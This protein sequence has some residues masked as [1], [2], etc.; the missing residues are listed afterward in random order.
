VAK[1]GRRQIEEELDRG[2]GS[3]ALGHPIV[4][5]YLRASFQR[6][7]LKR[8]R[9]LA[10]C[11]MP[12]HVHVVVRLYTSRSLDRVVEEWKTRASKAARSELHFKGTFWKRE[13]YQH[14]IR[15]GAELDRAL[16]YVLE[17]PARAGISRR[18]CTWSTG[19]EE[20][21]ILA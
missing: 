9:L 15:D 17:N 20:K 2:H 16:H 8:Y 3:C 11:V 18:D 5:G 14:A 1:F 7:N 21:S 6:W 4:L 10:W 13:Y 19:L 12:N